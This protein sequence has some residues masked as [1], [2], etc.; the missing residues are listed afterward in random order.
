MGL[1]H[2]AMNPTIKNMH[3]PLE[4]LIDIIIIMYD[5]YIVQSLHLE[6]PPVML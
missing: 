6:N 2:Y 1:C 3:P 5:A 4:P